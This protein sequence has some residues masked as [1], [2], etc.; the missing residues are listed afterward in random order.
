MATL[1]SHAPNK[2]VPNPTG[3]FLDRLQQN[4]SKQLGG[5]NRFTGLFDSG[6]VLEINYTED[7][8]EAPGNLLLRNTC[9]SMNSLVSLNQI[10]DLLLK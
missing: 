1:L 2:P 10:Q 7:D 4:Q 6:G 5:C 8:L 9:V 3:A